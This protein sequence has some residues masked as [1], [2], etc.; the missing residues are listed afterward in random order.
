MKVN[1]KIN[2]LLSFFLFLG[3]GS[4]S[5]SE[6]KAELAKKLTNPVSDLISVPFQLNYDSDIGPEDSSS[7]TYINVQPVIP[8]TLND[9]WNLIS[10]T[11]L[12]V[13]YQ[14]DVFSSSSGTQFGLGDT[15]QSLFFS[16]K[17]PTTNGWVW[18]VGPVFLIPTGTDNKLGADKWGIGPTV[19]A[20]RLDGHF[21]Y[22]VL[23][24]H[25]WS[26][27][28]DG[29]KYYGTDKNDISDT[30][31]QPFFAYTTKHATTYTINSESTYN[32]T[33]K[34]WAIPIN[35]MVNQVLKVQDQLIQV[36]GGLRYWTNSSPNGAEGL[37]LR[38]QFVLLFPE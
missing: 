31:I 23:A 35:L 26:F 1:L 9:D 14:D 17:K 16:P 12:P 18:G 2:F 15:T 19:V 3:I 11:I 6:D 30:F 4:N 10:R 37:G 24:N 5:Y 27:A 8:F 22:G 20:L 33:D 13:V 34:Q 38:F 36:G 21:T 7:K 32:W 28:G 29:N 25:L